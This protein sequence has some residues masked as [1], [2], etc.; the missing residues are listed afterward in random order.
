MSPMI[1]L[2]AIKLRQFVGERPGNT[3]ELI[4]Q[5]LTDNTQKLPKALANA[6]NRAR[7]TLA[8]ALLGD[9][10]KGAIVG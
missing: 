9:G 2:G 7:V 3:L 5:R 10:R 1:R 8:M 4:A 6:N